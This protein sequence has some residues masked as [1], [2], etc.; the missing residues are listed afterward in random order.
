MYI[1]ICWFGVFSLIYIYSYLVGAFY[2]YIY[3][4]NSISFA[5]N[6]IDLRLNYIQVNKERCLLN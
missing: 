5:R 1:Y 4:V 6:Y 2:I 3:D